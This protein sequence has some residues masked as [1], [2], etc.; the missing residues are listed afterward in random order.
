MSWGF[1]LEIV[2]GLPIWEAQALYRHQKH[3][4]RICKGIRKNNENSDCLCVY[5]IECLF[6][7]PMV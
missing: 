2:N 1:R 7:F 5:A 3:I 6:N 4:D